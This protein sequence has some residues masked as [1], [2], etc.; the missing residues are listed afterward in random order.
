MAG[1]RAAWSIP[2]VH[3]FQIWMAFGFE[4]MIVRYDR[5]TCYRIINGNGDP[6]S[7]TSRHRPA[8]SPVSW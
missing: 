3:E 2:V 8:A 5:I 4:Q 7:T 1:V 6:M